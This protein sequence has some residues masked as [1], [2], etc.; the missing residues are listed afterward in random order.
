[1][2]QSNYTYNKKKAQ[3]NHTN[4]DE[5]LNYTHHTQHT[6]AWKKTVSSRKIK[7]TMQGTHRVPS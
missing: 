2:D 6:Q 3:R 5:L 7:V 4:I 1:M